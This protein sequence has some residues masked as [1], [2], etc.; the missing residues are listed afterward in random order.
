[1]EF[2]DFVGQ[3]LRECK[4]CKFFRENPEVAK[5]IRAVKATPNLISKFIV[6]HHGVPMT[7]DN[8]NDHFRRGHEVK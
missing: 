6:E 4:L 1:M 5:Q 3:N 2:A 8:V 7:R